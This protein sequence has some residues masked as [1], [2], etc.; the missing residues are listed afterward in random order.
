MQ[1]ALKIR[2]LLIIVVHIWFGVTVIG[3][4]PHNDVLV[5]RL[6]QKE[7]AAPAPEVAHVPLE[8]DGLQ[9]KALPLV[10]VAHRNAMDLLHLFFVSKPMHIPSYTPLVQQVGVRINWLELLRN[11]WSKEQKRFEGGIDLHLRGPIQLSVD[12]GYLFDQSKDI[13][14]GKQLNYRSQGRYVLGA[15]LYV[16]HPKHFTNAY[17]GIAYGQSRF[18]LITFCNGDI[19][20]A[21]KP[22]RAGWIKF[23]G[24]SER[25]LLPQLYGG[26]QLGIAHLVHCTKNEDGQ[27]SNYTIPGYGKIANKIMLDMTL[28]LKW[29]VSF[30][31]KKI[32]I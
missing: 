28:Y 14:Y 7:A 10:K 15:L 13:V 3:A 17:F 27:V 11:L 5:S 1:C 25:R 29:S 32:V 30:L 21:S 24:G 19:P 26:M 6:L 23:I 16:I 31:E 8:K 12:F 9:K 20:S 4:N 22:F 18:D 2:I